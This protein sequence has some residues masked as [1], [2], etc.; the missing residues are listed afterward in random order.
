MIMKKI[1]TLLLLLICFTT[2]AQWATDT[3]VNL[4]VENSNGRESQSVLTSTG[5]TYIVFWSVIDPPNNYEL[6]LQV[7]DADG[8]KQ[9]GDNGSLISNTLPMSTFTLTYFLTVD[10]N[11]NLYVGITASGDESGHVFK[12]D[13]SGN[14]LWGA[15]G[16]VVGG[17]GYSVTILPLSSGEAIV[18]WYPGTSALMQKYDANGN[19]VW[20]APVALTTSRSV[21]AD[22]FEMS[23]GGFMMIYHQLGNF[24]VS[25]TL[26][27]QRYNSSGVAQWASPTQMINNFTSVYNRKFSGLQIG[28]TVYYGYQLAEN[29]RFDSYLQRINPDGSLPWGINGSDFDINQTNYEQTTHIAHASGSQYI[30]S[31]CTY[32][33]TSQGEGGEYIQKF[34]KDTGARLL[35]ENAKEVFPISADFIFHVGKKLSLINGNPVFMIASGTNLEVVLLDSNGDFQWAEQSKPFATSSFEKSFINFNN[36]LSHNQ[37]IATFSENRAGTDHIYAQNFTDAALSVEDFNTF[38]TLQ[39]INPIQNTLKL[40]SSQNISKVG[41]YTIL[42][43]SIYSTTNLNST[44]V[45]INSQNWNAGMYLVIVT[46]SNGTKKSIKIIKK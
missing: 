46:I 10:A 5:Q 32:T 28:D 36:D 16:V 14:Q 30:W 25:S 24:G 18:S 29:N 31:L 34:D 40:K 9:L 6:R 21:P 13:T 1:T 23:D 42:G 17:V 11:D 8:N 43:Q 45:T 27:A 3:S 4:L 26:H 38:S 35:T 7:L 2:N 19:P 44:E 22:M 39:F 33:N 41:V 20:A 15:N 12:M 37:L